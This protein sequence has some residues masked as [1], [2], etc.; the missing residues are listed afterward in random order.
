MPDIMLALASAVVASA[1]ALVSI[2]F[3]LLES[4]GKHA[5]FFLLFVIIGAGV[6]IFLAPDATMLKEAQF[7]NNA[8]VLAISYVLASLI[9]PWVVEQLNYRL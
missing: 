4:L 6:V 2:Q 8:F 1:A 7:L 3:P 9:M 5:K